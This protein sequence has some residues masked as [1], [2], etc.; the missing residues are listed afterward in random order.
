MGCYTPSRWR[1]EQA[2]KR[3][4]RSNILIRYKHIYILITDHSYRK[5][6][7]VILK[8][9]VNECYPVY[10]YFYMCVVPFLPRTLYQER[11]TN[12]TKK[13]IKPCTGIHPGRYTIYK[14]YR[15][16]VYFVKGGINNTCVCASVQQRLLCR[17]FSKTER[18][19]FFCTSMCYLSWVINGTGL[20]KKHKNRL[21]NAIHYP[22]TTHT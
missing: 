3:G 21:K 20:Q 2:F 11:Y 5:K 18:T 12:N 19:S 9:K 10:I 6:V 7:N 16:F 17:T 22:N 4:F 14:H 1:A 8:F 15:G 13:I